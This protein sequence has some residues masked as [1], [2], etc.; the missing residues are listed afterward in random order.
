MEAL[1]HALRKMANRRMYG[2]V[3]GITWCLVLRVICPSFKIEIYEHR[4]FDKTKRAL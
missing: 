1:N 3:L 4:V 2:V